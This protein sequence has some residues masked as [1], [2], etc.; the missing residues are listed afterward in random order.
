MTWAYTTKMPLR[1]PGDNVI[2]TF[3]IS[4]DITDREQT[5]EALRE[6]EEKLRLLL[7]STAEAIFGIDLHNNCTFCNPARCASWVTSARR[8]CSAKTFTGKP[9][10]ATPTA[11]T[12]PRNSAGSTSPFNAAKARTWTARCS[13]SRMNGVPHGVLVV[14]AASRR[15]DCW[16]RGGL[17]GHHRAQTHGSG[18]GPGARCRS[19]VG[20]AEDEFLANMSHEIRTPMNGI[21]GMTGLLLD[22]E[23]AP[24]QRQYGEVIRNS[25]ETC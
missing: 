23:Y 7:D 16:R 4:R 10:T 11:S 6:S 9:I 15:R 1:D 19:G 21:I 22:S 20:P 12:C 25:G 18:T 2:G 13:G 3:G 14:S 17:R 8:I 24:E 5:E